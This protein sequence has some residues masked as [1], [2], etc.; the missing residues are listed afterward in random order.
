L[1]IKAVIENEPGPRFLPVILLTEIDYLL[2]TRLGQPAAI[3]FLE[4]VEQGAF[5]LVPMLSGDLRRSLELIGQYRDLELGI[6]DAAVVAAAER[7]GIPRLLTLDERHFRAIKP[8]GFDHF[9]LLPSDARLPKRA[10]SKR[11]KSR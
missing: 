7:L 8:S 2:S 6:A 9:V 10:R 3:D 4:S 1:A 5:L 11:R